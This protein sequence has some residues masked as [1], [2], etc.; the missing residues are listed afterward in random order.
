[1]STARTRPSSRSLLARAGLGRR[2]PAAWARCSNLLEP[3]QLREASAAAQTLPDE[4]RTWRAEAVQL[5]Q[6]AQERLDALLAQAGGGGA[7]PDEA[8]AAGAARGRGADQRRRRRRAL[9]TLPLAPPPEACAPSSDGA[10]VKL[11]WQPGARARRATRATSSA[12][13]EQRPPAAPTDGD[14]GVTTARAARVRRPR[15]PVA[16]PVC[17][18]AS[19]RSADGRPSSRPATVA[20]HAAAAGLAPGGRGRPGHDRRCTGPRIRTRRGPGD[21]TRGRQARPGAGAG[22]RQQLP[23]SPGCPRG[24]TQHF[25]V[26]AVYRGPDGAELRSAAEQISVTPRVGGQPDPEAADRARSSRRDASGSG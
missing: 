17:S 22:D 7:D 3:G 9:A 13:P 21:P 8:Q 23:R 4:L 11:F 2:R 1:M 19:S 12:A 25:E 5:V 20:G 16:R 26:V 10:A 15:A 14:R 6:A 18:T 24:R